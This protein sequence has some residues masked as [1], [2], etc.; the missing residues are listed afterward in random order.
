[1]TTKE[2]GRPTLDFFKGRMTKDRAVQIL[3]WSYD[4][5]YDFYNNEVTE[6]AI[7][8][9]TSG[10]YQV[11]VNEFD[12]VVGFYCVGSPAQVFAGALVGVYDRPGVDVGFGMRPDLTGQGHGYAFCSHILDNIKAKDP[13][14][15]KP[16]RLT[17]ATFNKRAIH[18][19][20]KL[21]FVKHNTFKRDQNEF[22]TMIKEM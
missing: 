20:E 8:E 9:L 15:G 4:T 16:L 5:P 22:I 13:L 17:V 10:D 2:T 19:Y 14:E 11:V 3:K 18:L 7:H 12:E 1:M 6:M 21:G